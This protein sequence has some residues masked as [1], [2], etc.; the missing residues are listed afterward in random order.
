MATVIRA[1]TGWAVLPEH[2]NVG[3]W[4]GWVE[5]PTGTRVFATVL[6][7]RAP[8]PTFLPA[9]QAVT[10]EVLTRLGVLGADR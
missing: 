10:R 1:K 9:R 3:W 4:V 2:E 5:D 8:G 6:E 7:A